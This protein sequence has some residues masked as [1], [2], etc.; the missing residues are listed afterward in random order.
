M[1]GE[2]SG[3]LRRRPVQDRSAHTVD[4]ILDTAADLLD[5]TGLAGLTP[6]AIARRA[7]MSHSGI[8]RYFADTPAIIRALAARNLERFLTASQ[9]VIADPSVEWQDGLVGT[10]EAYA[11]LMRTEP[12]FR[13]LRFGEEVDRHL[14]DAEATNKQLIGRAAFTFF[15]ERF[16]AWDRDDYAL[17]IEALLEMIDALIGRAFY[18]DPDGEPFFIDEAKRFSVEYLETYLATTPGRPPVASAPP[19][20]DAS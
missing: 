17:R 5:E 10:I 15:A 2:I 18:S 8:Y 3:E 13:T 14:L 12:G 4:R 19:G 20:V 16:E 9:A 1:A 6:S 11:Q 7:G